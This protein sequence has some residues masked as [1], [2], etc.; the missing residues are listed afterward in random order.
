MVVRV[1]KAPGAIHYSSITEWGNLYQK[2]EHAFDETGDQVFVDS[3][4]S[5][6]HYPFLIKAAQDETA[7]SSAG[8]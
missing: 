2:L 4:F 5:K 6:G 7:T 3:A 1:I 8:E